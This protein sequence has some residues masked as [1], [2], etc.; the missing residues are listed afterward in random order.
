MEQM[1]KRVWPEAA[2]SAFPRAMWGSRNPQDWSHGDTKVFSELESEPA[3]PSTPRWVVA[4]GLASC[5]AGIPPYTS[6][7]I[8]SI[9]QNFVHS[10]CAHVWKYAMNTEMPDINF[11]CLF[12]YPRI[13]PSFFH[14]APPSGC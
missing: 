7:P 13:Y 4:A 8:Q 10:V 3:Q 1:E 11:G 14:M 9:L 6:S 12:L 5:G 2:G